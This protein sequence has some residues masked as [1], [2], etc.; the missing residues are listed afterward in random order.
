MT[1]PKNIRSH[2]SPVVKITKSRQEVAKK[3]PICNF[4]IRR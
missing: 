2:Q 4:N 3:S 1:P